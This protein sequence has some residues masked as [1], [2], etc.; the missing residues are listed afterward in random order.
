[1]QILHFGYEDKE[2]K[3]GWEGPARIHCYWHNFGTMQLRKCT[4]LGKKESPNIRMEVEDS[5]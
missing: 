2:V 4:R 3:H 1:M 5:H